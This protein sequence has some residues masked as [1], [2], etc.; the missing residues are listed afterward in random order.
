MAKRKMTSYFKSKRRRFTA[1]SRR[2]RGPFGGGN[3]T[4]RRRRFT[5]TRRRRR[6]RNQP[7]R[8]QV[9]N[10]RIYYTVAADANGQLY[11][12]NYLSVHGAI[13]EI[14]NNNRAIYDSVLTNWDKFKFLSKTER[15]FMSDTSPYNDT[16]RDRATTLYHVYDPDSRGRRMA[17][18]EMMKMPACHWKFIRPY[19][20]YKSTLRPVFQI[21]AAGAVL[22]GGE[23]STGIPRVDNPWRDCANFTPTGLAS[24][25]SH[26][27]AMYSIS[28]SP[29]Q[30]F[31]V[32]RTYKIAV[33]TPRY[34]QLYQGQDNTNYIE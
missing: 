28:T 19:Q 6:T 29:N 10:A 25:E 3:K 2:R 30:Q 7:S 9:F 31:T 16:A 11:R 15:I 33:T 23:I 4:S 20:V 1:P 34:G 14:Q 26:N 8:Y 17:P 13:Q 21:P 24:L 12:N 18:S 27:G 22:D 32:I 5:R